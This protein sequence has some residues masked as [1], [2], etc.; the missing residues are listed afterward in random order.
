VDRHLKSITSLV[1]L[2]AELVAS[3]APREP[4]MQEQLENWQFVM[5]PKAGS[6]ITVVQSFISNALE[7]SPARNFGFPDD[8]RPDVRG[9]FL[10]QRQRGDKP[11]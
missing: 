11:A 5:T 7:N 3:N 8:Q 1:A 10:T 9:T 2:I 4:D 6:G